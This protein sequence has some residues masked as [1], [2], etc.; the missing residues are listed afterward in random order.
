MDKNMTPINKVSFQDK[1]R[2]Y[3]KHPGSLILLI[4]VILAA[5]ITVV[6]ALFSG[7]HIIQRRSVL[8]AEPVFH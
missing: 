8:K 4:L 5:V 6:A 3:A 1:M 2:S 7:L